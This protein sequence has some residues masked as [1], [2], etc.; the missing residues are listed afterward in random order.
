MVDP[1]PQNTSS[2]VH[3]VIYL[4]EKNANLET[5]DVI[6]R[7]RKKK[8]SVGFIALEQLLKFT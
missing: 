5:T 4:H 6:S 3:P 7:C 1:Q 8:L 2:V